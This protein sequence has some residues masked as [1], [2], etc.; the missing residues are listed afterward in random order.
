MR[1]SDT[2]DGGQRQGD[3]SRILHRGLVI[4]QRLDAVFRPRSATEDRGHKAPTSDRFGQVG[5][6]RN[7]FGGGSIISFRLG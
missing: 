4:A 7:P 1:L 6:L 3:E 2:G 5:V